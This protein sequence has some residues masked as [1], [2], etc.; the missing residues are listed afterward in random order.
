[1]QL[2][3]LLITVLELCR[4]PCSYSDDLLREDSDA[5]CSELCLTHCGTMHAVQGLGA[6]GGY[7][8]LPDY[9]TYLPTFISGGYSRTPSDSGSAESPFG[10]SDSPTGVHS[11]TASSSSGC[12]TARSSC[13][14]DGVVE[15]A[16]VLRASGPELAA[17]QEEAEAGES[18][19]GLSGRVKATGKAAGDDLL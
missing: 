19:A 17:G 18:A 12:R 5:A 13:C 11:P 2:F 15:I 10:P 3:R 14:G 8:L 6:A 4:R 7:T 1:M 9:S 16:L